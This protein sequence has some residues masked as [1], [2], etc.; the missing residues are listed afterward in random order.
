MKKMTKEKKII[1]SIFIILFI[2]LTILGIYFLYLYILKKDSENAKIFISDSANNV[3]NENGKFNISDNINESTDVVD[4]KVQESNV[5]YDSERI[6][7]V[8]DLQTQNS[9]IVG[10]LEISDTN[11]SYPILQGIDNSYYMTHNYKKRKS[12]NGSLFLDKDYNWNK[13]STNLLIYGHNNR[14]TNEM[15]VELLKY[16]DESFYKEHPT[17]RF[18]TEKEDGIYEIISVFLSRV[19]YKRETDV[20][21][22]YYF[23]DA[24]NKEEFD[25]YVSECKKASLYNIEETAEYGDQLITLSTCEYSQEDG[26]FVVVARKQK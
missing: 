14:G 25:Y 12:K 1:C 21:R 15:F 8:K 26:R 22:Y 11:I 4:E 3:I 16:K 9:D 2:I 23:I 13:P 18:T 17:I 7:K 20:F 5:I 24:N 10:W 19:Y 6:N